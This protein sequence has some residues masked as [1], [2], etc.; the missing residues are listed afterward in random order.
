MMDDDRPR[1]SIIVKGLDISDMRNC[2][3]PVVDRGMCQ[4]HLNRRTKVFPLMAG[5]TVDNNGDEVL[6]IHSIRVE[7]TK[8]KA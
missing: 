2:K 4:K 6:I 3:W 1:C 5:F 8:G 7:W